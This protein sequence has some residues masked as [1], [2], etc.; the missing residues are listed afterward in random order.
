MG[1]ATPRSRPVDQAAWTR[2]QEPGSLTR[3]LIDSPDPDW[4]IAPWKGMENRGPTGGTK[5]RVPS[6]LAAPLAARGAI[7][8]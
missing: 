5:R 1:L 8:G 2:D 7:A 6:R 4:R 3:N